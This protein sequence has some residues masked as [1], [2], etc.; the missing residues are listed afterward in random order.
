MTARACQRGCVM[1]TLC[2]ITNRLREET[3]DAPPPLAAKEVIETPPPN[4]VSRLLVIPLRRSLHSQ[5][6]WWA[7]LRAEFL[8]YAARVNTKV[9]GDSLLL[10]DTVLQMRWQ[11]AESS[12]SLCTEACRGKNGTACQES[13]EL[14]E[15]VGESRK[16]SI[17]Y[18]EKLYPTCCPLLQRRIKRAHKPWYCALYAIN[19]LESQAV[20][21]EE[22]KKMLELPHNCT[23]GA[24]TKITPII[25]NKGGSVK[26]VFGFAKKE[27]VE[28]R[29]YYAV[30]GSAHPADLMEYPVRVATVSPKDS[31]LPGTEEAGDAAYQGSTTSHMI[32]LP[33]TPVEY[34]ISEMDLF[35]K[36]F[37]QHLS[38][39]AACEAWWMRILLK[40]TAFLCHRQGTCLMV[41][42]IK[43]LWNPFLR[44][45]EDEARAQ[46]TLHHEDDTIVN[47]IHG[48]GVYYRS[49]GVQ[50]VPG[51]FR[52][53]KYPPESVL[54]LRRCGGVVDVD[55]SASTGNFLAS[56][57]PWMGPCSVSLIYPGLSNNALYAM[58]ALVFGSNV[59]IQYD[60]RQCSSINVHA[61]DVVPRCNLTRVVSGST[62]SVVPQLKVGKEMH[63]HAKIFGC[64]LL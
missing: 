8:V 26:R 41:N 3:P 22:T 54:S 38:L 39:I 29:Q 10:R 14:G 50:I 48:L 31:E 23:A 59:S 4:A 24:V 16:L 60:V 11:R 55:N 57:G 51:F 32:L 30:L 46:R 28:A 53:R 49:R 7:Q 15:A 18:D 45:S 62:T 34:S 43:A 63:Y 42:L 12:R 19:T 1:S 64:F 5:P 36:D 27:G 35:F 17:E 9:M 21:G 47:K 44:V 61:V 33:L 25:C 2:G 37:D 40:A 13:G 56:R 58:R 52:L 6:R 20:A